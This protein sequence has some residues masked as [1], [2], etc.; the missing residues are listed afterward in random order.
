MESQNNPVTDSEL[1]HYIL[2][3]QDNKQ[4]LINNLNSL[5]HINLQN[6]ILGLDPFYL[7][8]IIG[9]ERIYFSLEDVKNR[10]AERKAKRQEEK[11]KKKE[12]QKR[13]KK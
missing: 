2:W 5:Y 7:L 1:Q 6:L 9:E 13:R 10:R 11:R 3:F 12:K 4:E 8:G